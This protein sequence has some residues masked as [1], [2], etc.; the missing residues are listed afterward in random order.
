MLFTINN[1]TEQTGWLY[2]HVNG[3]VASASTQ[4]KCVSLGIIIKFP[5]WTWTQNLTPPT[6]IGLLWSNIYMKAGLFHSNY[7]CSLCMI[8]INCPFE[9]VRRRHDTATCLREFGSAENKEIPPSLFLSSR[10]KAV[11]LGQIAYPIIGQS[12]F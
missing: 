6:S 4:K 2:K 5:C 10:G 8:V 11:E 12:H 9:P 3:L 7:G 1:T